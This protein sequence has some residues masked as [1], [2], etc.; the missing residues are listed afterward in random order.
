ME[1]IEHV[2]WHLPPIPILKAIKE[3]MI[4]MLKSQVE[5]GTLEPSC[6]SYQSWVF[7]VA[8]PTG[9]L[10]VVHDLQPL[11]AMSVQDSMLP[12][13]I[14]EF[15]E[16]FVGFSVYGIID[17]YSGYHQWALYKESRPLTA[18][19]M[20]TGN[21][22]LTSLPM[23]YTN[24]MQEYQ[25]TTM[26]TT[27]HMSLDW[28]GVFVDDI[29]LKGPKSHYNDD[30]IPQ[31]P[32]IQR[33]IWE[34][35]HTLDEM[36]AT[37]IEVG[38]TTT[39]KKLVLAM[40]LVNIVG[41]VCSL[42]GRCP[43]HGIIT[44]VL[45]W[46]TPKHATDIQAF[47]GTARVTWHWAWQFAEIVKPLMMLTKKQNHEFQGTSKVD[48]VMAI[49]KQ[50]MT[51]LPALKTLDIGLAKVQRKEMWE[52]DLGLVT[53]A[54]NS[55]QIAIGYV[56]YQTLED[57]HHPIIYGS[58]T[59]NEVESRY[60]QSKIELYGLYHASKALKYDLWG[61][62][63]WAELDAKYIREMVN[64][65]GGACL[66][67]TR[68]ITYIQNFNFEFVHIPAERHTALDGLSQWQHA[69]KDMDNTEDD[70]NPEDMGYFI[71]GMRPMDSEG[72]IQ[73]Q[74][75]PDERHLILKVQLQL[76]L[77]KSLIYY[78]NQRSWQV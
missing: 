57:S 2:L 12:P 45:N 19:Q 60:S 54:V 63:F 37:F 10:W 53:L 6:S 27:T 71:A 8:K 38:C 9:G 13:N 47:L 42:E 31:N 5:A 40:W 41:N 44:K 56:L 64:K 50:A 30:L 49:L 68:W 4:A 78:P 11:N 55:S 3:E 51:T 33:F 58:I 29:G 70:N 36:L 18:C 22:Q 24:S 73:F 75:M 16:S 65:P 61:I 1:T 62:H 21:M 77:D 48:T 26:H 66:A 15:V 20:E 23:G 43:H 72:D 76:D 35:A 39:R 69:N 59:W 52:N 34:Y 28:A 32:G 17:L 46:P 7:I 25:C 74:L 67:M 14:G